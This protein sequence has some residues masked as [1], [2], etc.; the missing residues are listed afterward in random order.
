VPLELLTSTLRLEYTPVSL[1]LILLERSSAATTPV[2][3][4]AMTSGEA[5]NVAEVSAPGIT[6]LPFWYR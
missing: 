3:T 4:S 6:Q 2:V 5:G 1:L